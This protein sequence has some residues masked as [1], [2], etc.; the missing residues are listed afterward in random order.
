[1]PQTS[2]S[3]SSVL[4]AGLEQGYRLSSGPWEVALMLFAALIVLSLVYLIFIRP[5]GK[6]QGGQLGSRALFN[7]E[8]L[9]RRTYINISEMPQATHRMKYCVKCGAKTGQGVAFCSKCGA[10]LETSVIS[11]LT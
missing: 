5:R 7:K 4:I 3:T 6:T 1:M 11:G 8:K 2:V 9:T 10:K